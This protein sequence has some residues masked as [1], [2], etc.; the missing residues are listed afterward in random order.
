MGAS[1][2][3]NPCTMEETYFLTSLTTSDFFLFANILRIL[4]KKGR[5]DG[6][7]LSEIGRSLWDYLPSKLEDVETES[8]SPVD[9]R[10]L[11]AK[12]KLLI[13]NGLIYKAKDHRYHLS[14]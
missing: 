12:L 3:K 2:D 14:K 10:T 6:C 4:R 9:R 5:S 11:K 1:P 8:E 13:A 7:T